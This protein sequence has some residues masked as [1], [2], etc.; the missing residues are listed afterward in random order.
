[1]KIRDVLRGIDYQLLQKGNENWEET[2][3]TGL[4]YDS[5]KVTEGSAFACENGTV[6]DGIDFLN[7]AGEKGAV[8][9][10]MDKQPSQF[11]AGVS[12]VLVGDVM[13]AES[14]MA[15]NFYPAALEDRRSSRGRDAHDALSF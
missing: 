12:M 3:V 5:R 8:L 6:Y 13:D 14:R 1:M 10:V 9:A 15:A 7:M 4:I 2:E 11:P